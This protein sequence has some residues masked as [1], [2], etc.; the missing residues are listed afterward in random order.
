MDTI[1]TEISN[2]PVTGFKRIAQHENFVITPDLNM[3]QQVRVITV[4]EEGQPLRS[5][6]DADET[7][8]AQQKQAALVRYADQIVSRQTL[9]AF[10]DKFGQVVAA[11]SEGAISQ[12]DFFQAI[13]LGDLKKMGLPISDKTP[14][15]TLIYAL[16]GQEMTNLDTRKAL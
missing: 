15:T 16:I 8:S 5:V 7:L 9:G 13:T 10:V 3:V 12:R 6:I 1:K 14:V 2:E 11:D 4:N